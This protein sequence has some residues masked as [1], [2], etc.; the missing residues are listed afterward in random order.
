MSFYQLKCRIKRLQKKLPE[1]KIGSALT[2]YKTDLV[3]AVILL[4]SAE[5]EEYIE[6][7]IQKVIDGLLEKWKTERKACN[8]LLS[9]VHF[10]H[11]AKEKEKIES[12]KVEF[13]K[14]LDQIVHLAHK[15]ASQMI[16]GNNGLSEKNLLNL[17]QV[18]GIDTDTLATEIS[19]LSSFTQKRG[20][21][22]HQ[23]QG[24]T[25]VKSVLS[26]S[27]IKK[28]LDDVTTAFEGIIK[29]IKARN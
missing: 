5:L 10:M 2:E 3:S 18:I 29:E 12:A 16:K 11:P 9:M 19:V 25:R 21:V 22:A 7:K 4:S 26:S 24:N 8:A 28:D 6:T 15:N 14:D 17:L 1:E 13:S 23:G 27:A 20:A